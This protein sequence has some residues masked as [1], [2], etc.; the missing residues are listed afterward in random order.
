M[1]KA[2]STHQTTSIQAITF[3]NA[4][5]LKMSSREIAWANRKRTQER[6]KGYS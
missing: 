1:T 3:A 4:D 6:N 2:N 5:N